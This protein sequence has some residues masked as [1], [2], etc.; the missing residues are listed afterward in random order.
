MHLLFLFIF[1]FHFTAFSTILFIVKTISLRVILILLLSTT[2]IWAYKPAEGQLTLTTGLS[3][4]QT[5]LT[6]D[7]PDISAPI[8]GGLNLYV[9]G[10]VNDKGDAIEVALMA[11]RK[12]Y[13]RENQGITIGESTDL[14][15]ISLGYRRYLNSWF[16][17]GLQLATAYRAGR[18]E[19]FHNPD[20]VT[21]EQITTSARDTTDYGLNIS[22]MSEIWKSAHF[23]VVTDFRYSV[24]AGKSG[25]NSDMSTVML[26]VRYVLQDGSPDDN[27][28]K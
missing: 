15:Q 8:S 7:Q 21:P 18:V 22:L 6:I 9:T 24:F 11:L 23:S 20:G 25:E 17:A 27:L 5:R 14:L 12:S 13:F 28:K 16:S 4:H 3:M 26:G 1:L 10:D 19:V 2:K